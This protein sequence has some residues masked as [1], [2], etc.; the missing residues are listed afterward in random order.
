MWIKS[1]ISRDNSAK[2][3]DK[4]GITLCYVM[5]SLDSSTPKYETYPHIH[6]TL[7]YSSIDFAIGSLNGVTMRVLSGKNAARAI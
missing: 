3:V 7:S 5:L 6:N 2:S 1:W 4:H